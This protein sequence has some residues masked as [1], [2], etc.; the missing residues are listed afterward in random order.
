MLSEAEKTLLEDAPI[1][2]RTGRRSFYGTLLPPGGAFLRYDPGCLEAICDRGRVALALVAERL[3]STRPHEHHWAAGDILV[4]DNWRM[5]HGR[6]ACDVGSG[7]S[8]ARI[9]IDDR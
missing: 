3:A 7:R 2:V 4:I 9:L 6:A 8:L 5:L 1:L